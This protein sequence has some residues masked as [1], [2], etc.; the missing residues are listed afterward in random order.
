MHINDLPYEI[1]SAILEETARANVDEGVSW[2]YGLSHAFTP[3]QESKRLSRYIKGPASAD[4]LRWDETSAIRQVCGVWHKWALSHALEN[5]YIRRWRGSERWAELST[6]RKRYDIYELIENPSGCA[7]YRDPYQTLRVTASFLSQHPPAT[8]N[9]RRVWFNGFYTPE[10][11]T[12]IFKVMRSCRLLTSVS[13]PW[14]VLRHGDGQ[15]WRHLLG[16]AHPE[17]VPVRS[18]E[19]QAVCLPDVLTSDSRVAS[20]RKALQDPRVDFGQLKRLKIFGNT[21]FMPINDDDLADIACTANGL[22]EFHLT[23]LSTVSI[24]GVMDIVKASQSTI[25]VLEHSPRSDDGFFHPDPG[26]LNTDEHICEI[27]V[28]CPKLKD[29]SISVPTMCSHLF[30]NEDVLW[31]GECQVR[32]MNLCGGSGDTKIQKLRKLLDSARNLITSQRR[33]HKDLDIELFFA[34]CIFDPRDCVVH[35]YFE[36]VEISS[37]GQWPSTKTSSSK[38]PYGS[39]GLYGKDEGDWDIVSEEEFFRAVNAGWI[40]I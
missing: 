37:Y 15:D 5:L 31:Q 9:I 4:T 36:L 23:C 34:D 40:K 24:K 13:V 7:V 28:D 19:L 39:T 25:R 38:G 22:E 10:A 16:I 3:L 1:L 30:S 17:D 35:G 8:D 18:L 32:A 12:M 20:D 6:S 29:L 33:Q 11:E 14:T 26:S 27:L 21:T 2:T